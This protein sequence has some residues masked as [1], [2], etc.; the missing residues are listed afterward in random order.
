MIETTVVTDTPTLTVWACGCRAEVVGD[1]F[2]VKPCSGLCP[3][4]TAI[5]A[6][7]ADVGAGIEVRRV[8][9]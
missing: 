5:V 8:V 6:V 7:G 1:E 3:V 9:P 4:F 2:Q